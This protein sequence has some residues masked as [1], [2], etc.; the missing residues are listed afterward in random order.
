MTACDHWIGPEHRHCQTPD[1]RHYLT[2]W[3]CPDHTPAA[4]A[5][6]AEPGTA[7]AD[8]ERTAA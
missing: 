3:R 1:A 2:G 7:T 6:R 8:S 4:L 5:G